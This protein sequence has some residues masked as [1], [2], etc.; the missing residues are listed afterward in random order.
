MV[1]SSTMWPCAFHLYKYY[2]LIPT[3]MAPAT[4]NR[5][6]GTGSCTLCCVAHAL[7]NT[8]GNNMTVADPRGV[9]GARPPPPP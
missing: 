5:K 6:V 8:G 9:Q 1:D 4:H 3:N 2:F 7:T